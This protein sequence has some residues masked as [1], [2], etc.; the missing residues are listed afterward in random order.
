[1]NFFDPLE[2]EL[3]Q[4]KPR[5]ASPEFQR[6]IGA[7]LDDRAH[8]TKQNRVLWLACSLAAACLMAI[9]LW[10]TKPE[11]DHLTTLEPANTSFEEEPHANAPTLLA[12]RHALDGSTEA[13]NDALERHSARTMP[14]DPTGL[15]VRAF[16]RS[17]LDRFD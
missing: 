12:Y 15:T 10:R 1:M 6:Q 8:A 7:R 16:R 3:R 2:A 11:A 13:L 9:L 5:D 14:R 17:D 4:L